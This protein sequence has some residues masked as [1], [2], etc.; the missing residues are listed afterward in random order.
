[1]YLTKLISREK[2][3]TRNK[4]GHFTV[5]KWVLRLEDLTTGFRIL[6][7]ENPHVSA[8]MEKGTMQQLQVAPWAESGLMDGVT[9]TNTALLYDTTCIVSMCYQ[10]GPWMTVNSVQYPKRKAWCFGGRFM[11]F[12]KEAQQERLTGRTVFNKTSG[13]G[14]DSNLDIISVKEDDLEKVGV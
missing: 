13:L 10:R 6:N 14:T 8:V 5:I 9:M 4:D 2:K 1:M 3:V 11:N 12:I 7:V